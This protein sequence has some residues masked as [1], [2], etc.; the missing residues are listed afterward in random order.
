MLNTSDMF[1][2][3]VKFSGMHD[4]GI[5][6]LMP[7]IQCELLLTLY[8]TSGGRIPLPNTMPVRSVSLYM[9]MSYP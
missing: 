6:V 7:G 3:I 2:T 8:K 1:S 4:D 5:T 9:Y